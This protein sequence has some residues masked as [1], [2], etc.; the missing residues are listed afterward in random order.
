[1]IKGVNLKQ[2]NLIVRLGGT[3]MRSAGLMDKVYY[4][5]V[6]FYLLY[7]VWLKKFILHIVRPVVT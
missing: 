4:M 1:M 7:P 3:R 5:E 2:L 6:F